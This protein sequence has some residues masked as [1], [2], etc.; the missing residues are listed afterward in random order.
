MPLSL[1]RRL[2]IW[3]SLVK[4]K[5]IIV[6]RLEEEWELSEFELEWESKRVFNLGL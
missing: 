2:S 3:L 6:A 1:G 4:K 5:I